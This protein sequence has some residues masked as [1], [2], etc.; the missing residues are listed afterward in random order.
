[1]IQDRL[2]PRSRGY[3]SRGAQRQPGPG[4]YRRVKAKGA[5]GGAAEGAAGGWSRG[6]AAGGEGGRKEGR[7][8]EQTDKI[9]EPLTEVRE[10]N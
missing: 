2:T 9:R 5:A 6:G 7:R 8:K 10:K 1:M 3:K 4:Q